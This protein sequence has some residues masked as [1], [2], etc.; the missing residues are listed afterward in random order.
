MGLYSTGGRFSFNASFKADP[1]GNIAI[2]SQSGDLTERFVNNLNYLGADFS[3]GASIGNSISLNVTDLIQY[4]NDDDRIEIIGVYFEGF[5]RYH[6]KEGRRLFEFV[7]PVSFP[8]P[9]Q[10]KNLPFLRLWAVE[11]AMPHQE[12]VP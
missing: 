12:I 8:L 11:R 1:P 3:V 6:H 10:K 9:F 2:I 4:F 7:P 5:S